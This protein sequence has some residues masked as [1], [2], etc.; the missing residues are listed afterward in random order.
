[1]GSFRQ[2]P[3]RFDLDKELQRAEEGSAVR[4]LRESVESIQPDSAFA[5]RLESR[6]M[7]GEHAATDL[8][9]SVNGTSLRTRGG[10]VARPALRMWLLGAALA[11]SVVAVFW[12]SVVSQRG[13]GG[14]VPV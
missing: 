6:L 12:L 8:R 10:A 4:A 2:E 3:A 5:R 14:I 7:S 1:M 9:A 11:A 13:V